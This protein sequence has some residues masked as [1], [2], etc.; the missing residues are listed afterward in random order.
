MDV[1]ITPTLWKGLKSLTS[2]DN[3]K[4]PTFSKREVSHYSKLFV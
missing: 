2:T 4:I 1:S 3:V